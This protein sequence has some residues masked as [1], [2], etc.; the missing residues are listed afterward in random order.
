MM[1]NIYDPRWIL[2]ELVIVLSVMI[3][4]Q[5]VQ[6]THAN[7]PA[8][9]MMDEQVTHIHTDDVEQ[10]WSTLLKQYGGY[11]PENNSPTYK[12]LLQGIA[13]F[14]ISQV[15]MA[16]LRYFF[17]EVWANSKLLAT[18]V[19]LTLCSMLLETIQHSF[20]KNT[21]SKLGNTM[22]YMVLMIIALNSFRLALDVAQSAISKMISFMMALI[23]M[24]LSLMASMGHVTTVA[25]IHPL[26]IFMIHSGGALISFVVFP[27]LLFS[28]VLHVVTTMSVTYKLTAL[29]NFLRNMGL[30]ILAAFATI[31]LGVI[32]VQSATGAIQDGVMIRT[33]KYITG[34]FI[35]VVGRLFSDAAETV[36]G[37]SLLVKHAVGL[38][39]VVIIGMLCI[40]PACKI[41]AIALMYYLAAAVIQP[42][43]DH[44]ITSCLQ[45]IGK[46]L[47][48][49]FAALAVVGLMF[50]LAITI[51]IA[52]SNVTVM[53][54]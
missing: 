38:S 52:L 20:E 42:L 48:F 6:A 34:N 51:M 25:I 45:T 16:L 7:S 30:L 9:S 54:R 49:I 15:C 50:F 3:A 35:P 13:S 41:I 39:G 44:P 24:L 17:H 33:A 1:S 14:Q 18:L 19:L 31:F 53:L 4:L 2:R 28:T 22:T 23:P 8:S 29:A 32:S 11:F 47:I 43:G 46:S 36:I 40:F 27:L 5:W 37:A 26:M 10:Y 12:D 21:V